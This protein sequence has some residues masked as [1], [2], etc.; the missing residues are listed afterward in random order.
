M[1]KPQ[2]YDQAQGMTGESSALPAGG[3]ICKILQ[4][5][6]DKSKK[7]NDMLII[8]FDIAEGD[9]KDFYKKQF[10]SKKSSNP[11]AKWQGIYRQLV[12]GDNLPYFKGMVLAIEK[13]NN[14]SWDFDEKKLAGKLFGGV[15]GQEEYKGNDGKTHLSTKCQW[16]R[17]VEQIRSGNFKIPDVKRLAG[18]NSAAGFTPLEE[19]DELPF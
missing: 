14:F 6:V 18:G 2:G 1:Q 17:T 16:I 4:A 5:K 7:G 11:E 12:D 13:S 8:L 15:F 10:E 19:D 9:H 3:Y